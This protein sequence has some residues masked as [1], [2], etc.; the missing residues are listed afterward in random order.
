M[1]R[2][3][4]FCCVVGGTAPVREAEGRPGASAGGSGGQLDLGGG[5]GGQGIG[6]AAKRPRR[7]GRQG[8][9]DTDPAGAVS[10]L[11]AQPVVEHGPTISSSSW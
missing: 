9:G 8:G 2:E 11:T 6:G 7:A 3:T 1:I 4:W 5:Q 10:A